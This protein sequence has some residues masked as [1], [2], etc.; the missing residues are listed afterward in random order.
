MQ[1]PTHIFIWKK[2]KP[3]L[4]T[5]FLLVLPVLSWDYLFS[6]YLPA[7]LLAADTDRPGP[8]YLIGVLEAVSRIGMFALMLLMPLHFK[9]SGQKKGLVIYVA[10]LMM[11]IASWLLLGLLP[12]SPWS[13]SVIGFMSPAITPAIWLTGI[14][15]IGDRTYPYPFKQLRLAYFVMVLIFLICHNLETYRLYSLDTVF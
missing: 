6:A 5:C 1:H 2:V 12:E 15:L 10:G 11:Y 13:S 4:C 7:R 9:T 14:G 3:Y 8:A